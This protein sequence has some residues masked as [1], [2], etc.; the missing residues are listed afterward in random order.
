MPLEYEIDPVKQIVTIT[1]DYAEP[2]AWRTLLQHVLNDPRYRRGASFVRD[3]RGSEHPVDA[4][5]VIGI[6]SVVKEHWTALGAHRAAIVMSS[7]DDAPALI[8]HALADFQHLP[9]RAFTSYDD[10]IKWLNEQ[11]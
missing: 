5:A 10:A 8:A 7:G 9:L 11:H 2:D 6:I 1:G 4:A 3:L